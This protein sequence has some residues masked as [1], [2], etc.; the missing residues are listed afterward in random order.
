MNTQKPTA[1]YLQ[2]LSTAS[3]IMPADFW[4]THYDINIDFDAKSPGNLFFG[5]NS[6]SFIQHNVSLH[7]LDVF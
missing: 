4:H 7:I 3:F 5:L 2:K 1:I 6:L